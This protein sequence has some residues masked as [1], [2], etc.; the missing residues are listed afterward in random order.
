MNPLDELLYTLGVLGKALRAKDTDK[1]FEAV[2]VLLMEF[3]E[4]FG[5]DS[6]IFA[7]TFPFLEKLKEHIEKKQ[8]EDAHILTDALLANIRQAKAIRQ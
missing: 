4:F 2:T 8:F 7:K 6:S 1:A 3:T 5:P